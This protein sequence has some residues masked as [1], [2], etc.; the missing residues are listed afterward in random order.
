MGIEIESFYDSDQKKYI[1]TYKVKVLFN[2]LLKISEQ[3]YGREIKAHA[4]SHIQNDDLITIRYKLL[5]ALY[6]LDMD[7]EKVK[8]IVM[9]YETTTG[10]PAIREYHSYSRLT[11]E[12]VQY[13]R[14]GREK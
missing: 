6:S 5:D 1:I 4:F 2:F 13:W 3:T 8:K 7:E 9:K 11:M 14:E 10:C 12:T